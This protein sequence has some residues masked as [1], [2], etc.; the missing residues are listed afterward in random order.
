MINVKLPWRIFR[1]EFLQL[2]RVEG[3][4]RAPGCAA[5]AERETLVDDADGQ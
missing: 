1:S 3:K 4:K 2:Q 5:D